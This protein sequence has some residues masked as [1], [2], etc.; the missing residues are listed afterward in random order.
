MLRL[1]GT[2]H[3]VLQNICFFIYTTCQYGA[4]IERPRVVY[5]LSGRTLLQTGL[6]AAAEVQSPKLEGSGEFLGGKEQ[7]HILAERLP[8]SLA[9]LLWVGH[10]HSAACPAA[11]ACVALRCVPRLCCWLCAVCCAVLCG[12]L[13]T[14][15]TFPQPVACPGTWARLLGSGKLSTKKRGRSFPRAGI[16]YLST[17]STPTRRLRHENTLQIV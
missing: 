8:I 4:M 16:F 3:Y 17:T 5:V 2:I 10:S 9:R 13:P 12:W 7:C 14:L 15:Y 6:Q 11:L 1:F